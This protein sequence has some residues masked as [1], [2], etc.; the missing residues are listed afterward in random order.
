MPH[1]RQLSENSGLRSNTN[2]GA[3]HLDS[4]GNS[5]V[6]PE[7]SPF[8]ALDDKLLLLRPI[9]TLAPVRPTGRIR[10]L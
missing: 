4:C 8:A 1:V 10:A 5:T 9:F 6:L 3:L 2:I 7:T